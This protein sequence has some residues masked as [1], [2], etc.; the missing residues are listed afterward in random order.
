MHSIGNTT[1]SAIGT[2]NGQA[3]SATGNFFTYDS[4]SSG[5]MTNQTI[6]ADSTAT[7]SGPNAA[8]II[9]GAIAGNNTNSE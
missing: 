9:A 4:D 5:H 3:V 7:A 1:A 2:G 6:E 8:N